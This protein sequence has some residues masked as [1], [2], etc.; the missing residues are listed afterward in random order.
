MIQ[1]M[2]LLAENI[3]RFGVCKVD[4]DILK[5]NDEKQFE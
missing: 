5:F 3:R 1:Q 2:Y 4:N